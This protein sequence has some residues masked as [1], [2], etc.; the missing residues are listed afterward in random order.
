MRLIY[1]EDAYLELI[2]RQITF[3]T[4]SGVDV[5]DLTDALSG[6]VADS[7][8]VSGQVTAFTPGSTAGLTTIEYESGVVQ[9]LI[10]AVERLAPEGI[11][12]EHEAR[13]HDGNGHS[14]V[15]AALVGPSLTIPITDGRLTLGTWQQAVLLDFDVRPRDRRVLVQAIGLPGEAR[16]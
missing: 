9:D 11:R 5:I 15:R 8:L 13:W 2:S 10:D 12:Y 4:T 1:R 3:P 6:L 16:S 14:H 7:G